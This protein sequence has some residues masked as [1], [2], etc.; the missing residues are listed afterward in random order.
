MS[1]ALNKKRPAEW[2]RSS[3]ISCRQ[4]SQALNDVAIGEVV[5][6]AA[7]FLFWLIGIEIDISEATFFLDLHGVL[8]QGQYA[9]DGGANDQNRVDTVT[10]ARSLFLKSLLSCPWMAVLR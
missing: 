7:E 3:K 10:V 6:A 1:R 5:P 4:I 8:E 9:R 2:A